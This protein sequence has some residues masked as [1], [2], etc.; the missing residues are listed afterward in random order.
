[1]ADST[2]APIDLVFGEDDEA[3]HDQ[4]LLDIETPRGKPPD[5]TNLFQASIEAPSIIVS[6]PDSAPQEEQI[7]DDNSKADTC[8]NVFE[9]VNDVGDVNAISADDDS[10]GQNKNADNSEE[11]HGKER[12]DDENVH[13]GSSIIEAADSNNS[14]ANKDPLK[15]QNEK[16]MDKKDETNKNTNVTDGNDKNKVD[17]RSGKVKE[18]LRPM[19]SSGVPSLS[20]KQKSTKKTGEESN[21]AYSTQSKEFS[22]LKQ[23]DTE[24]KAVIET[25]KEIAH[26]DN[27]IATDVSLSGIMM[28]EKQEENSDDEFDFDLPPAAQQKQGPTH[29]VPVSQTSAPKPPAP[30]YPAPELQAQGGQSSKPATVPSGSVGIQP[31][32]GVV[33]SSRVDSRE[34]TLPFTSASSVITSPGAGKAAV[35]QKPVAIIKPTTQVQNVDVVSIPQTQPV[36]QPTVVTATFAPSHSGLEAAQDEWDKVTT[37]Q[38]GFKGTSTEAR[39]VE[40]TIVETV[41]PMSTYEFIE[42]MKTQDFSNVKGGIKCNVERRGLSAFVNLLFGPPKLHRDLLSERERVFCIAASQLSNDNT[43]HMRTLQ[44]IYK[45]LTGSKFDCP[46]MGSHWEEIGFQGMDPSTDLRGAGLLGLMNLLYILKD[47]KKMSLASD[48]YRLSI[49]PTQNFPFCVMGIN[50]SR[51]TLQTLREDLL[52][53]ECNR[54]GDVM[55]VVNEFYAALYFQMYQVWK[56]QGKTISDSGYVIKELEIRAKKNPRDILRHLDEYLNRKTVVVPQVQSD[57]GGDNFTNVCDD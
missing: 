50:L 22:D 46:R 15:T 55:S 47:P 4:I 36:N 43:I 40:P 54:R 20:E 8:F 18:P 3:D 11:T 39:G 52:N 5:L 10:N 24:I 1:M 23:L 28:T 57:A 2:D 14:A 16:V 19:I 49:H 30:I 48:I 33:N 44:T 9:G 38:A 37:I 7:F 51:I 12:F 35:G 45:S 34:T 27:T 26:G 13:S 53:K 42:A 25:G 56:T 31:S 21:E 6:E 17:S 32:V 29:P 41:K